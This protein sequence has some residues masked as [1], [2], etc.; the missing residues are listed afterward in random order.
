MKNDKISD[1]VTPEDLENL[2]LVV[3][4]LNS[5][6]ENFKA[7]NGEVFSSLNSWKNFDFDTMDRLIEKDLVFGKRKNKSITFTEEGEELAQKLVRQILGKTF[8]A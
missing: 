5:W 6:R 7:R 2:T 1:E 3:L 8:K 4:Y